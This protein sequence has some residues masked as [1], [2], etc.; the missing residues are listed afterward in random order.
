[1]VELLKKNKYIAALVLWQLISVYLMAVGAWPAWVALANTALIGLCIAALT[2]FDALQL[3][4]VS[5]PFYVVLPNPYSDTLSMWRLLV[6]WLCVV[7]MAKKVQGIGYR[8]LVNTCK[9]KIIHFRSSLLP[10]DW[11]LVVFS[12]TAVFSMLVARYPAESAKQIIFLASAALVSLIVRLVARTREQVRS[13]IAI[14]AISLGIIVALGYIQYIATF[15]SNQYYFWQYWATRVSSLYYGQSLA[16]VLAYSNSWF[17]TS[18]G[19]S[20]LRMFSIM[21]DSHSFAM[22]AAL[23]IGCVLSIIYFRKQES[24]S[25]AWFWFLVVIGALAI[26]F[27]GTRGVWVGIL[28]P[29][30]IAPIL[31]VKRIAPSAIFLQVKMYLIILLC[32][33]LSPVVSQGINLVRS[34]ESGSF[35]DRAM[36]VYDLSEQSNV[37]RLEIWKESIEYSLSHPVGVGYANFIVTLVNDIPKGT[38]FE[39]IGELPNKRY[40]LPQ[41]FITA[42]NL[43]LHLLV[44]LGLFGLL[45]FCGFALSLLW[46]SLKF[47]RSA[48]D[49]PHT[50]FIAS[51]GLVLLWFFAYAVFDVTLFNDKILLYTFVGLGLSAI[52]I[53]QHVLQKAKLINS[54]CQGDNASLN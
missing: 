34:S 31:Y 20:S 41:K 5:I 54:K 22:I 28:A 52:I 10:W 33:A 18:G 29:F 19:G 7:L 23:F 4:I 49:N 27:A 53:E 44:E 30:I 9:A 46:S 12:S 51:F 36:S 43:Y 17:S 25:N 1:M 6:L 11:W 40:N 14:M 32:F 37:G 35:F 48:A 13:L 39:S 2:P 47:L 45:A 8:V 38:S 16:D 3:F 21:P 24:K 15:F 26:M 42:H 50:G